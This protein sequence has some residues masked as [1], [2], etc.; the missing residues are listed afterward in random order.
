[1]VNRIKI[2]FSD[3]ASQWVKAIEYNFD[4]ETKD[5]IYKKV[6]DFFTKYESYSGESI[7]QPDNTIINASE[8][9]AEI[10]DEILQFKVEYK[11]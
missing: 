5:K 6:M 2:K 4:Q 7:C 11:D 3:D 10:A 1:M 8:V 9:L